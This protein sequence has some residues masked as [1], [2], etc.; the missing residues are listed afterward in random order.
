MFSPTKRTL[1]RLAAMFAAGVL[2]ISLAASSRGAAAF[3][4]RGGGVAQNPCNP[5]AKKVQN[6]C[7]PCGGKM[8]TGKV[9][10]YTAHYRSWAKLTEPILSMGHGGKYVVTYGNDLADA[11]LNRGK[12]KDGARFV[13]EGYEDAGGHPGALTT[14]YIME[15]RGKDWYYAMIDMRGNI[16]MEGMSKQV[17]MCSSCHVGAKK[18]DQVFTAL[19]RRGE[20]P[21]KMPMN[22]CNPCAKKKARNPCNPCGKQ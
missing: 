11:N 18:A 7:N 19:Q 6:P 21:G 20:S 9:Y 5:C 15:K 1:K 13:K 22:P 12:F 4:A 14:L 8:T 2:S 10:P 16:Q 3:S 17:Q